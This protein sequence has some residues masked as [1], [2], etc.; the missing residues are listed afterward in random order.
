[1]VYLTRGFIGRNVL[2]GLTNLFSLD[3]DVLSYH[4]TKGVWL[5]RV[6]G[7]EDFCNWEH[8]TGA[9]V[10]WVTLR[11]TIARQMAGSAFLDPILRLPMT[12]NQS[13]L[14]KGVL[15]KLLTLAN[16]EPDSWVSLISHIIHQLIPRCAEFSGCLMIRTGKLRDPLTC[17]SVTCVDR[18]QADCLV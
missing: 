5:E 10:S 11:A 17:S 8:N 12:N 16:L 14:S 13:T 4:E 3:K 15:G 7:L 2:E 9:S 1:M 18:L 6:I